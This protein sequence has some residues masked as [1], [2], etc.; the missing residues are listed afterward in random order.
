M[1]V[2]RRNDGRL[3]LKKLLTKV[4]ENSE[5]YINITMLTEL[6]NITAK[7]EKMDKKINKIEKRLNSK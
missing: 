3:K 1:V 6:K 2:N 4:K 7:L 5:N